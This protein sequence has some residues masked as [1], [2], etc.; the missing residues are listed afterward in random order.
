MEVRPRNIIPNAM[1]GHHDLV[2]SQDPWIGR[3][4][5]VDFTPRNKRNFIME[6]VYIPLTGPPQKA[7]S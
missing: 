4:F 6:Q 3:S 2:L 1:R 7:S 5:P